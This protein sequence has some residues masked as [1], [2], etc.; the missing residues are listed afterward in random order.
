MVA[1]DT[2]ALKAPPRKR[3]TA[4][5][6]I[7]AVPQQSTI[8]LATQRRNEGLMGLGQLAQ[9][10]CIMSGQYADAATIGRMFPPVALE[11]AKLAEHYDWLAKPLDTIIEVGPF[12]ALLAAVIP[13]GLQIAANHKLIDANKLSGQ[14]IVPPEIL[15]AQMQAEVAKMQADAMREQQQAMEEARRAQL[16]YE[17]FMTMVA[18]DRVNGSK[19]DSASLSE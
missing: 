15:T 19:V 11:T 10:L 12:G 6:A 14:G 13:F 1:I 3:A 4:Q 5:K 7:S 16:E 8:S 17:E 18:D 2:S 9:G